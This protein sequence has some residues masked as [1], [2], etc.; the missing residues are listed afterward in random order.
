M[1]TSDTTYIS[2]TMGLMAGFIVFLFAQ[3]VGIGLFRVQIIK[4]RYRSLPL[5]NEK[6]KRKVNIRLQNIQVKI[7]KMFE[8]I[9]L[10][11]SLLPSIID[12]VKQLEEQFPESGLGSMKFE[13]IKKVLQETYEVSNDYLPI[14]EKMV[15]T[16]VDVFN[17]FGVFKK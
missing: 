11:L 12:V 10:V 6:K 8:T 5:A 4:K 7:K 15:N 3:A 2:M 14:I 9:K 17:Q 1:E 16:V 13:L